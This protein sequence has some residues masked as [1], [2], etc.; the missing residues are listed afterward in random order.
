MKGAVSVC[1]CEITPAKNHWEQSKLLTSL[2]RTVLYRLLW[3]TH[4]GCEGAEGGRVKRVYWGLLIL[5]PFS[6]RLAILNQSTMNQHFPFGTGW[7]GVWVIWHL[8]SYPCFIMLQYFAKMSAFVFT[9]TFVL[10]DL[11]LPCSLS[12][13]KLYLAILQ[14]N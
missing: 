4:N 10:F 3:H 9:V 13:W 6:H 7:G 8:E 5:P 2:F 11:Y 12:L 1:V 14:Q